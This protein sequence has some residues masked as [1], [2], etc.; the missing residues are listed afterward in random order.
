MSQKVP[1][2]KEF[3]F[4]GSVMI[5]QTDLTGVITFANRKFCEVSGYSSGELV[6]KQ[7]N[8]FRDPSMPK[9]VFEKMWNNISTGHTWNGLIKNLRK[10]GSYYW[11]NTEIFPIKNENHEITGFIAVRKPTSKKNIEET[12]VLYNKMRED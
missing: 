5:T 1:T 4:E 7:H 9:A 10:D 11:S 8:I 3:L 6:G 2:N 12:Q